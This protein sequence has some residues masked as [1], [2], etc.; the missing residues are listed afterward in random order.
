MAVQEQNQAYAV[1]KGT[2]HCGD[3]EFAVTL[4]QGL[5]DLSRCNCSMCSR[6]GAIMQ[7]VPLEAFEILKGEE[8]LSLYQFKTKVAE[9]YFCSRCGIYTHHKRRSNPNLYSVNVACLEGVL[10]YEL[11]DI[12]VTDGI[13]HSCDRKV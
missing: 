3:V 9:H 5:E 1:K 4:T 11:G 2:C 7:A 6:R 12:P 10:P 8:A 13:N